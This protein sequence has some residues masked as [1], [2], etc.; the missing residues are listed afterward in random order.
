MSVLKGLSATALYGSSAVNGAI[1]IKTKNLSKLQI[2]KLKK[3]SQ[4]Y[5]E[6]QNE[7][8]KIRN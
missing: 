4:L 7:I 2:K 6:S 1:I 8:I 5:L 3:R